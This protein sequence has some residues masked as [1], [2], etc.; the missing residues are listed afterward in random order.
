[1]DDDQHPI[2]LPVLRRLEKG[3]WTAKG[4]SRRRYQ[5]LE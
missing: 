5:S 1:M 4:P 2:H 3:Q